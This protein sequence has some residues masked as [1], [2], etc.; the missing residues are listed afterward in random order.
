[1]SYLLDLFLINFV[2][3]RFAYVEF[4]TAQGVN[5]AMEFA[6]KEIDRRA[7]KIS[8]VSN[9]IYMGNL[10]FK[11]TEDDIRKTFSSCGQIVSV[12]IP[13]HQDTGKL[14]G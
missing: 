1:L 10:S 13:T 3:F 9:T 4:A 14:K 8:E 5:N 7:I 12:R 11:V 6:G 2:I